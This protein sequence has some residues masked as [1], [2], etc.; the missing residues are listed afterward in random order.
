MEGSLKLLLTLVGGLA[1]LELI[2][3]FS[4]VY[5]PSAYPFWL[6]KLSIIG[7]AGYLVTDGGEE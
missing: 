1:L 3:V 2:W 5:G 7:L 6:V 4:G